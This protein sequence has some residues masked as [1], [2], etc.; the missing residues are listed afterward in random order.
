MRGAPPIMSNLPMTAPSSTSSSWPK[1]KSRRSALH[2]LLLL[3]IL[4]AL[5]VV[6]LALGLGLGL[7]LR[8]K[9]TEGLV[10]AIKT[11]NLMGHLKVNEG[12]RG[13]GEEERRVEGEGEEGEEEGREQEKRVM[14][15]EEC[16]LQ[17]GRNVARECVEES[18][19]E[20]ESVNIIMTWP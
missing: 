8:S 11:D 6:G 3:A 1:N 15:E 12:R 14:W 7:G 19:R 2:Y 16:M 5:I 13:G 18:R 20:M 4:I 9:E 10:N 17:E